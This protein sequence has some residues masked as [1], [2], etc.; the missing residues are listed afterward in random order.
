VVSETRS[1]SNFSEVALH[2]IGNLSI[3]QTGSESLVIQAEDDVVPYIETEVQGNRLTIRPKNTWMPT[4]TKPINY[5]LNV[6]NLNALELRGAGSIDAS[7]INT[8]RLRV[9]NNG[10]GYMRLAGEAD[11]QVVDI[12]GDGRYQAE[13]LQS[14]EASLDISGS[15]EAIIN[16]SS[17]LDVRIN[18]AGTVEYIGDPTISRNIVGPGELRR[19]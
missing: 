4:P 18:G 3:R 16:A 7:D 10:R 8:A 1:V 15:G 5:E 17:V 13:N 12:A 9:T 6:E 2:G 11:R 14:E 19:H